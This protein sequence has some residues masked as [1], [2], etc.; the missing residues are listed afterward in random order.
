M[1]NPSAPQGVS[2]GFTLVEL[3]VS[4]GIFT[5]ITSVAVMNHSRFNGSIVLTNLAYE[6]ALSVREAQFY[7]ITVR[8]ASTAS[9]DPLLPVRFDSGYGIHFD[10]AS[11]AASYV[12]FEDKEPKDRVYNAGE[13]IE[14][15]RIQKGNRIGRICIQGSCTLPGDFASVVDVTFQRPNPDSYITANG[16]TSPRYGKA[17]VCVRSPNGTYRKVVIESTGQI[18]VASDST[19]MCAL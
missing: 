2:P 14:T 18:S 10:T 8:G 12:L 17:E 11:D 3:L 6:I 19:G 1:K 15:Y 9:S 5:L 7:G 4:I 16:A 13:A